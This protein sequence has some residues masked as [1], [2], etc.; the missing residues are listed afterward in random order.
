[1]RQQMRGRINSLRTELDKTIQK[2]ATRNKGDTEGLDALNKQVDKL[3]KDLVAQEQQMTAADKVLL[4]GEV[5]TQVNNIPKF[6]ST[7][8]TA[9]EYL[10]D[11]LTHLGDSFQ[12]GNS[13]EVANYVA[14]Q[15]IKRATEELVSQCGKDI[16]GKTHDEQQQLYMDYSRKLSRLKPGNLHSRVH[17]GKLNNR[18]KQF[19]SA[20]VKDAG[21]QLEALFNQGRTSSGHL[22][23]ITDPTQRDQAVRMIDDD[24][25][26]PMLLSLISSVKTTNEGINQQRRGGRC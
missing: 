17:Q 1:M 10:S 8:D 9:D 13:S 12:P 25:I 18:G 24:R 3:K 26:R 23:S 5:T 6:D 14:G 15:T 16:Q 11:V 19:A 4:S 2:F 20:A 21:E 7:N 22:D